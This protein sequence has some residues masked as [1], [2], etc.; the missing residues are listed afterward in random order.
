MNT[1]INKKTLTFKEIEKI[2]YEFFCMKAR[3]ITGLI[4]EEYDRQLADE[5]DRNAYRHKGYRRTT[6]KTVYG[7]VCYKRAV[8]QTTDENGIRKFV[9]L[10]D[11]MLQ[12]SL[13]GLISENFAEKL[14]SGIT[15]KS[16]R[17]CA[18]ELTETT[19]QSISAMGVWKIIQTLGEEVDEEEK[20]LTRAHKKNLVHGKKECPVLFEEIDG[21]NIR[22]QGE[23]RKKNPSGKAEMKVAIAY[24][25]WEKTGKDRYRLHNKI[26]FAGFAGSKEFHRIREARIAE[27]F[28][29]DEVEVRVLNGDGATWIKKVPDTE[30]LFQLDPFH[31]NKAV[32]ECIADKGAQSEVMSF[33]RNNDIEGMF[34]YLSIYRDSIADDEDIAK[35]DELISYF[36]RNA[37]G[38]IPWQE[39][40]EVPDSPDGLEYRNMGTMEN[41]VSSII[42]NRMK[43]GHMTWSIKGANNFAKIMAKKGEGRLYEITDRLKRPVFEEEKIQEILDGF[44]IAKTPKHDGNG[45][46]YPQKGR[47]VLL[48]GPEKG[49]LR[50]WLEI[51]G[52]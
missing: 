49:N 43:K 47:I 51:A 31:R 30:T 41:H 25:G 32:R 12:I 35:A 44:S 13:V 19:G 1:I 16:Y 22:L 26:A 7:E 24:D 27:E 50:T 45:Y 33:L 29:L 21:V 11:E 36:S 23:D 2:I 40:C 5:R 10:L 37:K 8:Y 9:F 48:G 15:T 34:R 52:Y 14:V 46:E 28:N 17:K 18:E 20:E 3:K 42:A 39:Q 38:L 6:I 4:L